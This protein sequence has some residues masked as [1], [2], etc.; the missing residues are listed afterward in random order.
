MGW[1]Q[2]LWV[3][4][5]FKNTMPGIINIIDT[6]FFNYI[7]PTYKLIR[8]VNIIIPFYSRRWGYLMDIFS[9]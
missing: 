3:M 6:I 8:S 9:I 2:H 7:Q 1:R 5:R 4:F